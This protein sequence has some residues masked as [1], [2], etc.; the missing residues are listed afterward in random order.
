MKED[1]KKLI[2]QAILPKETQ[3]QIDAK[4]E[5]ER[6]LSEDPPIKKWAAR[7]KPPKLEGNPLLGYLEYLTRTFRRRS[8][9][10]TRTEKNLLA[11]SALIPSTVLKVKVKVAQVIKTNKQIIVL[12]AMKMKNVY[13]APSVPCLVES[14]LCN[15]GDKVAKDK[16]LI[17]FINIKGKSK[18]DIDQLVKKIKEKEK[19]QDKKSQKKPKDQTTRLEKTRTLINRLTSRG[20]KKS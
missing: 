16:I 10:A 4:E 3:E 18:K 12:E 20:R 15:E 11:I 8:N 6:I 13:E 14:I 5:R 2:P 19:R 7:K 1:G 9:I 17:T